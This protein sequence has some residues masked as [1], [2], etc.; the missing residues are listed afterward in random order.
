M[1][2]KLSMPYQS[3]FLDIN[4]LNISSREYN[5]IYCPIFLCGYCKQVLTLFAVFTVK[6]EGTV[7]LVAVIHG[8]TLTT[9][10]TGLA[11]TGVHAVVD[12]DA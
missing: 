5:K 2:L 10:E 11:H 6:A 4:N 8:D 7:A 12:V 1:Y 9:I 3:M